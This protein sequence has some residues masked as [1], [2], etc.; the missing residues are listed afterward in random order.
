MSELARYQSTS[1]R[2]EPVWTIEVQCLERD[3]DR[4]LDAVM[5]VYTLSYG[6]YQRNASISAQ[7]ENGTARTR[8]DHTT[9]SSFKAG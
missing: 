7:G 2:L 9:M 4:I 3:T 8:L 6:R 1:G 5:E